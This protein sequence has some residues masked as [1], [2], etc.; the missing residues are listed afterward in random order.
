MWKTKCPTIY[1]SYV[2]LSAKLK[3]H[4]LAHRSGAQNIPKVSKWARQTPSKI[5]QKRLIPVG[6]SAVVRVFS[7]IPSIWGSIWSCWAQKW[8]YAK[9]D[10]SPVTPTKSSFK[11]ERQST[12]SRF[13]SNA[14]WT[15]NQCCQSRLASILSQKQGMLTAWNYCWRK[16][17][18]TT[19][20]VKKTVKYIPI[21]LTGA[22]FGSSINPIKKQQNASRLQV[23]PKIFAHMATSRLGKHH[24]KRLNIKAFSGVFA[25]FKGSAGRVNKFR[26]PDVPSVYAQFMADFISKSQQTPQK[27]NELI[28]KIAMFKGSRYRLSKAHHFGA[29]EPLVFGSV[30]DLDTL[31]PLNFFGAPCFVKDRLHLDI[32]A[33][34]IDQ[35]QRMQG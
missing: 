25:L 1:V 29:L 11:A 26:S 15:P 28:P 8:F 34:K 32:T 3:F 30:I 16:K 2:C 4:G 24:Q 10:A 9:G 18:C 19:W 5:H 31:A 22:G 6:N 23:F 35:S 17:S 27:S 7:R 14:N 33:T 20:D 21:N 13:F 12:N